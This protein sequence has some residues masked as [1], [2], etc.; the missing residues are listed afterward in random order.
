M[1]YLTFRQVEGKRIAIYRTALTEL[2][3]TLVKNA[4]D[5]NL[6]CLGQLLKVGVFI[7]FESFYFVLK[8]L[9]GLVEKPRTLRKA[10]LIT[11]LAKN[12]PWRED[13]E[14]HFRNPQWRE[15]NEGHFSFRC[16]RKTLERY[17]W[18]N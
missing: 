7:S 15:D 13:N 12:P 2:M 16:G 1:Q 17:S 3:D 10:N 11:V 14:G 18:A 8:F 5:E 4:S 9:I 6:K